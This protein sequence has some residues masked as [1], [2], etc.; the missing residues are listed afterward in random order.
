MTASG[1]LRA[2][3]LCTSNMNRNRNSSGRRLQSRGVRSCATGVDRRH[4]RRNAND[5]DRRDRRNRRGDERAADPDLVVVGEPVVPARRG[6]AAA[7]TP[8]RRCCSG[9]RAS[10]RRSRDSTAKCWPASMHIRLTSQS[11]SASPDRTVRSPERFDVSAEK[12]SSRVGTPRRRRARTYPRADAPQPLS[13][14]RYPLTLTD[15]G[16]RVAI[17]FGREAV[18]PAVEAPELAQRRDRRR[19]AHRRRFAFW[20]A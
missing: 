13:S 15:S 18:E 10:C 2:R 6:T 16:A 4:D 8:T 14:R 19:G 3:W 9:D 17:G 7:P 20:R 12:S 5:R 11:V 1:F